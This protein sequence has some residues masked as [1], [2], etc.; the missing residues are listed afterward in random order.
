MRSDFVKVP[1]PKGWKGEPPPS[2]LEL[3]DTFYRCAVAGGHEHVRV[4]VRRVAANLGAPSFIPSAAWADENF[5]VKTASDGVTYLINLEAQPSTVNPSSTENPKAV[6][7]RAVENCIAEVLRRIAIHKIY[8][9]V[10]QNNVRPVA[11][12][13]PT[14]LLAAAPIET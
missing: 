5:F 12:P 4:R 1:T 3:E 13:P 8:P 2:G 14:D 7:E 11:P 9:L 6:E 10:P